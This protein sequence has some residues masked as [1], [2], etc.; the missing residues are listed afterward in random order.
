MSNTSLIVQHFACPFPGCK[1]RCAGNCGYA[2][3]GAYRTHEGGTIFNYSNR[4]Y[5]GYNGNY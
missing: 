4:L 5:D 3:C 2:A 1:N